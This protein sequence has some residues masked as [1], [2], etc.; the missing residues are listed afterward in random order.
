[1]PVLYDRL[2]SWRKTKADDQGEIR[3]SWVKSVEGRGRCLLYIMLVNIH[4]AGKVV[5][6]HFNFWLKMYFVVCV[7]GKNKMIS[8]LK[9]LVAQASKAAL[10]HRKVS[11]ILI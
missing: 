2:T 10:C 1:M 5:A 4:T 7:E 6:Q 8:E 3:C 11:S 9:D